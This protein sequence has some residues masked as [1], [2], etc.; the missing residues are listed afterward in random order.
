[1]WTLLRVGAQGIDTDK[2]GA[3][4]SHI[5]VVPKTSDVLT[6]GQM[7]LQVRAEAFAL[8]HNKIA[9]DDLVKKGVFES[10]I[11]CVPRACTR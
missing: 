9:R 5:F 8:K 3:V 2:C 1:M 10:F 4:P 11:A 6:N 7:A